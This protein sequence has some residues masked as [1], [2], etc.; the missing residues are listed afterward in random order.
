[1]TFLLHMGGAFSS[2][3]GRVLCHTT[4][5]LDRVEKAIAEVF[6][7]G[8]LERKHTLGHHGNE[9]VVIETST[10]SD[11][12][13]LALFERLD[14]EEL[15]ALI[16]TLEERIDESCN[17]FLRID[18]QRAFLGEL[19]LAEDDDV[20]AIRMKVRAFPAKKASAV[21]VV[22]ELLKEIAGQ[23]SA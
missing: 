13:A 3:H 18:K 17:L 11:D 5:R 12:C 7:G 20:V 19:R 14:S 16:E 1:M 21:K 6:G 15:E 8:E 23:A 22:S 10:S 2:M 4:E 9:I